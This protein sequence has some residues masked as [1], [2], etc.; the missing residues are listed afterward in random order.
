MT[1][2]TGGNGSYIFSGRT[3]GGTAF[4][5][6]GAPKQTVRADEFSAH[7]LFLRIADIGRGDVLSGRG[8]PAAGK[9]Q[10]MAPEAAREIQDPLVSGKIQLFYQE[11]DLLNRGFRP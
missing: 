3:G 11:I 1:R 5:D 6:A 9:F 7:A 2:T 8:L 10:R 4:R